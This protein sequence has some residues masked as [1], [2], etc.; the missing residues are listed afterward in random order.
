MEMLTI[1]VSC[2]QW[3]GRWSCN[4][5]PGRWSCN[6][7][8]G[9]WSCNQWPCVVLCCVVL[10]CVVLCC[11]VLCCVVLCCVVLC[12]VV[13][14]CVV[15]CCVVLCCVVLCCVVL[16]CVVLCYAMLPE[17][18]E[19]NVT[20]STV[21]SKRTYMYTQR[22]VGATSP[23]NS[24]FTAGLLYLGADRREQDVPLRRPGC[25][26]LLRPVKLAF[27]VGAICV[28]FAVTNSK[29]ASPNM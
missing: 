7:W 4:Q 1:S 15:L 19:P 27:R 26:T 21:R 24:I 14:C 10:C 22:C 11:V 17:R 28:L 2:N 5:W 3:P 25:S 12:C 29:L 13:L 9:R 6:Q 20:A 18:N 8:P 16:C 23:G